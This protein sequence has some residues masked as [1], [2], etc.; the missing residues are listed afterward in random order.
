MPHPIGLI[1]GVEMQEF[2]FASTST[3]YAIKT[4]AEQHNVPEWDKVRDHIRGALRLHR[5][6]VTNW[7]ML[8]GVKIPAD[9]LADQAHPEVG[10]QMPDRNG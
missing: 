2:L 9:L 4:V 8:N 3:Q 5:F 10:Q 1:D 6:M 7:L